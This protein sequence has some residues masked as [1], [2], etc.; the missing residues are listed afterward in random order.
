VAANC[1]VF[2][3]GFLWGTATSS[4]QVEGDN[5]GNDWWDWEQQPGRIRDGTTSGKAAEW[6]QGRAEEDLERAAALGQN[7]HR[8]SLEW[9]R[10]EPEPGCWDAA[11]F[12]RYLALFSS[13]RREGLATLV[14]LHHFTLPRWLARR[15]AW[16][17][18][19][20][21]ECFG[22]FA[23]ECALRLGGVVD[24]WATQNE[25]NVL[26]YTAYAGT[27]WPP[28]LGSPLAAQRALRAMLLGHARAYGALHARLPGARVGIV[29][30]LPGFDAAQPQ[31]ADRCAAALQRWAFSEAVL[32]A[33][34]SGRLLPPLGAGNSIAGLRRSFDWVGVNYYGRYEVAFDLRA[35]AE[36]F[37][38]RDDAHTVHTRWTDWGEPN[39]E[40]LRRTLLRLA[41]LGVPLYVTENGIMDAADALRPGY[42]RS[43]VQAVRQAISAGADVR[44]YFHW[45]LVDNFEWAEGWSARFGLF[46][47]DRATQQRT[48]R[49]S[50]EIYAA[51]CRANGL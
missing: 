40:G 2:P 31:L 22:R 9:S 46:A 21:A 1:R 6:W 20:V 11:A 49:E 44:G 26:A 42:L 7:V 8:F 32:H 3:G 37:G 23:A 24:L 13:A 28:G 35:A 10:L 29:L 48:L 41:K 38:R 16:L 33:L 15:G 4:H 30:S 39:P 25:P 51:I 12:A 47:L 14:T 43:H 27:H 18:P 50:G 5:R 34:T 17:A 19:D 36:L 45:S